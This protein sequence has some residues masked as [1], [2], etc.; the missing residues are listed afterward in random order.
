MA[1][2]STS[3]GRPAPKARKVAAGKKKKAPKARAPSRSRPKARAASLKQTASKGRAATRAPAAPK[4][5][6]P[7]KAKRG[8]TASASARSGGPAPARPGAAEEPKAPGEGVESFQF[9][10][11]KTMISIKRVRPDPGDDAPETPAAPKTRPLKQRIAREDLKK[12]K[13]LLMD[14][15]RALVGTIESEYQGA[16]AGLL[17][18]GDEG[19]LAANAAM[20]DLSLRLAETE[21]RELREIQDALHKLEEGSYGICE[22]TG[23]EINIRRLM[24]MPHAR[25]SIEAQRKVEKEQIRYDE[26]TEAWIITDEDEK[27]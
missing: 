19:D 25:L 9:K 22:A 10:G 3:K 15:V 26:E 18:T 11:K 1:R 2:K 14:R 27:P 13:T 6:A 5:A 7:R 16:R 24:A 21:S 23:L 4:S 8:K 20:S 17:L 12:L